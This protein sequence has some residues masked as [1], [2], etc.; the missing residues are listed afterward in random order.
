MQPISDDIKVKKSPSQKDLQKVFVLP[1]S[2]SSK[3]N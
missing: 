3:K 2:P 1:K